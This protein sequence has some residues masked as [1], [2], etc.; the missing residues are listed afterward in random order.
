MNTATV[1]NN[2]MNVTA[3][4]IINWGKWDNT[5]EFTDQQHCQLIMD[6]TNSGIFL[7]DMDEQQIANLFQYGV[8]LRNVP[9]ALLWTML[10]TKDTSINGKAFYDCRIKGNSLSIPAALHSMI[11]NGNITKYFDTALNLVGYKKTA[12][13]LK[14]LVIEKQ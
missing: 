1:T 3:D 2:T 7:K 8:N 11:I 4:D 12:D 9:L 14:A 13:G 5:S 10:S 6:M